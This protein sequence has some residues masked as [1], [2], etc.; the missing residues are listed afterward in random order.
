MITLPNLAILDLIIVAI[1]LFGLCFW[2]VSLISEARLKKTIQKESDESLFSP[3]F[4]CVVFSAG[5]NACTSA[6]AYQTKPIL[7]SSAP[8]LPLLGC[9]AKNC[10]CSLVKYDDRRTG[11]DRRDME[12]LDKERKATYA[13]KRLLKDRRRASIREFLLPK[14]RTFI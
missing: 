1:I 11:K 12:I 5:N 14:Y 2:L 9:S 13:N 10:S 4:T 3:Q 8:E 6:L 7:I